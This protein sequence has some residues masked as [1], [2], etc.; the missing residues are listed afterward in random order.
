MTDLINFL[1]ANAGVVNLLFSLV[2]AAA[3]VFYAFLTKRLVVETERMRQAQTEPNVSVRVEPH[4]D[5]LNVAILVIENVGAGPAYDL[6]LSVSPN[7]EVKLGSGLSEMGLFKH[8]MRYLAPRQRVTLVLGNM[9]GQTEEIE[10]PDGRFRIS[11][12]ATYRD[13]FDGTHDEIYPLDFLHFLGLT[14]V[15]TPPL[16]SIANDLQK[17]RTSL[18]HL[19]TG[20][21]RLKVE[22]FTAED[23]EREDEERESWFREQDTQ[24]EPALMAEQV[25]ANQAG[26]MSDDQGPP[27]QLGSTHKEASRAIE[28]PTDGDASTNA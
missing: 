11:V 21:R 5:F 2:V 9:I 28:S 16:R 17:I 24:N 8:G 25:S 19:E 4:D 20:W 27:N 6:R 3:T 1:N 22:T 13:V 23:R 26:T 15:G 14:R 18:E 10:K 12:T 7:F